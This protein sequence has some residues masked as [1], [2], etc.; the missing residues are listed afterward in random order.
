MLTY[1]VSANSSSFYVCCDDLP[2]HDVEVS[3]L[4]SVELEVGLGGNVYS[5]NSL[6]RRLIR[7]QHQLVR[8]RVSVVGGQLC[9]ETSHDHRRHHRELADCLSTSATV[10]NDGENLLT[11]SLGVIPC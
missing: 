5:T 1:V 10:R 3:C 8:A 6:P 9:T 7:V 4:I 11:P 2:Q